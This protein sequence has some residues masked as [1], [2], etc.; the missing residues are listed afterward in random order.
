MIKTAD[1]VA[2]FVNLIPSTGY[3]ISVFSVADG[4]YGTP[5]T[6]VV[7]TATVPAAPVFVSVTGYASM[8]SILT[9]TARNGVIYYVTYGANPATLQRLDTINSS[10]GSVTLPGTIITPSVCL[11]DYVYVTSYAN[12]GL[13]AYNYDLSGPVASYKPTFLNLMCTTVSPRDGRLYCFWDDSV[14]KTATMSVLMPDL[15]VQSMHAIPAGVNPQSIRCGTNFDGSQVGFHYL[16]GS[17]SLYL[18]SPKTNQPSQMMSSSPGVEMLGG[19]SGSILTVNSDNIGQEYYAL[20]TGQGATMSMALPVGYTDF[21]L[22][23]QLNRWAFNTVGGQIN[24][25]V[26]RSDGRTLRQYSFASSSYRG[27]CFDPVLKKVYVLYGDP[28]IS[29]AAFD[30]NL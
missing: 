12:D 8:S 17:Y 4:L 14:V 7:T 25:L 10:S 21:V 27:A 26:A 30:A 5:L 18:I 13:R 3:S 24:V 28:T 22:D 1:T 11:G 16:S 6:R 15:S 19:Y 29:V 20:E 23:H 9:P 2:T